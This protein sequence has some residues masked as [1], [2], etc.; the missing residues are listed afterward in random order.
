MKNENKKQP[1]IG[2]RVLK[3]VSLMG[4]VVLM[5]GVM[6]AALLRRSFNY[7]KAKQKTA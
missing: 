3:K 4:T 5:S 2:L 6:Y 1:N 7:E